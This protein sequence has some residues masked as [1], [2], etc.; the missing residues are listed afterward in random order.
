MSTTTLRYILPCSWGL[1][2]LNVGCSAPA[3][4]AEVGESPGA[5]SA[6]LRVDAQALLATDDV[7]R[8]RFVAE[9]VS[10]A[11]EAFEAQTVVSEGSVSELLL[12][13]SVPELDGQPLA[14]DSEHAFADK[15]LVL[16]PGCYDI[17]L[18]PLAANGEASNGCAAATANG[19]RIYP[20][21]TTEIVLVSQCLSQTGGLVDTVAAFNHPPGLRDLTYVD[22]RFV[23]PCQATRVCVT[24]SDLDGDPLELLWAPSSESDPHFTPPVVISSQEWA[25]GGLEQCASIVPL[26]PGNFQ[27]TVTAYDQA[28]FDG[29]FMRIETLLAQAGLS[30]TSHASTTFSFLASSAPGGSGTGCEPGL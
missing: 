25:E 22:G 13:V 1:W 4:S 8:L 15:L 23:E 12:P 29:S 18:T 10:C 24:A 20:E 14:P 21:L 2:A 16:A 6:L 27:F 17:T 30:G 9:R 19:V 26:Q 3:P 5:A 7:A 28:S 11:G